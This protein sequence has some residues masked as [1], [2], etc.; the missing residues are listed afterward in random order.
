MRALS[1]FALAGVMAAGV[2]ADDPAGKIDGKKLVGKWEPVD[3]PK[4]T[5]AVVEF[6]KDGKLLVRSEYGG[7]PYKLEGK[8]KLDGN[9]LAV[10]LDRNGKDQ[11][12]TMTVSKLTDD[13]LV[14]LEAGKKKADTLK[15]VKD[16]KK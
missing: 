1:T 8:Y 11:P 2:S 3:Q 6:A 14:W 15:R 13:E 10:V 16:A 4:G 9:K 12:A 7:Q 5:K